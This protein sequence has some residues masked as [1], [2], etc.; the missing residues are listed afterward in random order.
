[1]PR[2]V[3][4]SLCAA[5]LFAAAPAAGAAAD[6]EERRNWFDDPFAQATHGLPGCPP[7]LGPLITE[8]QMR[9]E[10][11]GRIERGTSCWLAG[12]CAEPNAYARDHEINAEVARQLAAMPQLRDTQLWVITQ[13]RFVFLQGCV[14]SRA[15]I[16]AAVTRVRALPGVDY[17]SDELMVGTRGRPPYETAPAR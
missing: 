12:R 1:M 14:R 10:A 5:V 11:H 4:S 13:R 15:Q 8:A 16:E 2:A 3:L 6:A 7:P 9:R 17:V